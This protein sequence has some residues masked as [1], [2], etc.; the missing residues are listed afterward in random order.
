MITN[1]LLEKDA[2]NRDKARFNPYSYLE[3]FRDGIILP[4]NSYNLNPTYWE[5]PNLSDKLSLPYNSC[6]GLK[7]DYPFNGFFI[8]L[9]LY[10]PDNLTALVYRPPQVYNQMNSSVIG[11]LSVESSKIHELAHKSYHMHGGTDLV[12]SEA[13]AKLSE[14]IFTKENFTIYRLISE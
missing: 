11:K 3:Q 1:F 7:I 12:V 4:D 10:N 2:L 9:G 5:S 6:W 14:N 8:E 13:F